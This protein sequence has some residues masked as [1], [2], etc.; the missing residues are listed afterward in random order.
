[1]TQWNVL[2]VLY[3]GY[4]PQKGGRS[5][6]SFTAVSGKFPQQRQKEEVEALAAEHSQ[7]CLAT[8]CTAPKLPLTVYEGPTKAEVQGCF[9]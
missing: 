4:F 8:N 7:R 5:P 9:C 2:E 3:L 6:R 1:M